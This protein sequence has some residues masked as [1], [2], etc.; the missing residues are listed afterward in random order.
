M[1][2]AE[3]PPL[4]SRGSSA[5]ALSRPRRPRLHRER[6]RPPLAPCQ[7]GPCRQRYELRGLHNNCI[8]VVP[9]FRGGLRHFNQWRATLV[10]ALPLRA[11]PSSCFWRF[12]VRRLF[13]RRGGP[14]FLSACAALLQQSPPVSTMPG[15]ISCPDGS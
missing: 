13:S 5:V 15:H 7:D 11:S 8:V 14:Y 1:I 4:L 3:V 6:P 12:R 10:T 9:C 2:N